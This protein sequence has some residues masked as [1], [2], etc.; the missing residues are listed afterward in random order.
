MEQFLQSLLVGVHLK[1]QTINYSE[2]YHFRKQ[3]RAR[4]VFILFLFFFS[5]YFANSGNM[6]PYPSGIDFSVSHN[7]FDSL[8]IDTNYRNISIKFSTL[9]L[10]VNNFTS[11]PPDLLFLTVENLNLSS[12]RISGIIPTSALAT[13]RFFY[14][15]KNQINGFSGNVFPSTRELDLSFNKLTNLSLE[16]FDALQHSSGDLIL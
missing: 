7:Q 3:P 6:M 9:D 1:F 2:I 10:S 8:F 5:I 12:N 14:L 13:S 16:Q 4:F 15:Q 11:I